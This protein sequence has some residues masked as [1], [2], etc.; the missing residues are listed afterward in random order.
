MLIPQ[1]CGLGAQRLR[2]QTG[3]S[4]GWAELWEPGTRPRRPGAGVRLNTPWKGAPTAAVE[5]VRCVAGRTGTGALE[6][7]RAPQRGY[8]CSYQLSFLLSQPP[9]V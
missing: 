7:L 9:Q 2:L 3:E 1:A 6:G 8:S 5:V 4:R